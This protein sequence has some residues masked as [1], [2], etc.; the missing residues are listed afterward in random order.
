MKKYEN[1]AKLKAEGK[2]LKE[3]GVASKKEGLRIKAAGQYLKTGKVKPTY[4][5]KY[6]VTSPIKDSP[7]DKVFEKTQILN[8]GPK[9]IVNKKSFFRYAEGMTNPV[10]KSTTVYDKKTGKTKVSKNYKKGGKL[11]LGFKE[12][13]AKIAAK[14]GISMEAAGAILAN[15]ARKASPAAVKKNPALLNVKRGT[16]KSKAPKAKKK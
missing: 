1:G 8:K 6:S 3:K 4:K 13:Q 5:Q 9:T 10:S 2:Y 14:Q 16:K 15:S 12:T 7:E 11:H